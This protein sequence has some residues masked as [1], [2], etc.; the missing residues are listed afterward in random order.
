MTPTSCS[1]E[2]VV[3]LE[4]EVGKRRDSTINLSCGPTI[5]LPD[6]GNAHD[7]HYHSIDNARNELRSPYARLARGCRHGVLRSSPKEWKVGVEARN[8]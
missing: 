4:V 5:L 3:S 6:E 2:R 1:S 7:D 8:K